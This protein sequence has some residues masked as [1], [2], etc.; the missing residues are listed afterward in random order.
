MDVTFKKKEE[1]NKELYAKWKLRATWNVS[2][3]T[4]KHFG[5]NS[6]LLISRRDQGW[7][8]GGGGGGGVGGGKLVDLPKV[9]LIQGLDKTTFF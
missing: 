5:Q 7:V 1:G 8:G 2:D 6:G 3:Q 9:L 4:T